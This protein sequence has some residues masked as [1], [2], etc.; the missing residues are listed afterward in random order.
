MC[1]NYFII[2]NFFLILGHRSGEH[3]KPEGTRD[4]NKA[5]AGN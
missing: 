1:F 5:S 2:V 3:R 4:K